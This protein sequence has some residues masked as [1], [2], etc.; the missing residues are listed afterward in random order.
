MK[1]VHHFD[2]NER[3]ACPRTAPPCARRNA[4]VTADGSATGGAAPFAGTRFVGAALSPYV[5]RG[6]SA[7][8]GSRRPRR[9]APTPR[10]WCERDRPHPNASHP[11]DTDVSGNR[12]RRMAGFWLELA[13]VSQPDERLKSNDFYVFSVDQMLRQGP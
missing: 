4:L 9:G 5:P 8:H 13:I 12:V 1:R 11:D 2:S 7:G 10:G 6:L 3:G